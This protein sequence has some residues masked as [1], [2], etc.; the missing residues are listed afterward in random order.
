[1][2]SFPLVSFHMLCCDSK[3]ISKMSL[4][5]RFLCTAFSFLY[6]ATLPLLILTLK[7]P[8][9]VMGC[10]QFH[11]STLSSFDV[12]PL[13]S[14]LVM[15]FVMSKKWNLLFLSEGSAQF[16]MNDPHKKALF[17]TLSVCSLFPLQCCKWIDDENIS[18]WTLDLMLPCVV[19][20]SALTSTYRVYP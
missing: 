15:K 4:I 12:F 3:S 9:A 14:P 10:S 7:P 11:I 20:G 8:T 17:R 2:L 5:P 18:S 1:M 6:A 13:V 16:T 19:Q